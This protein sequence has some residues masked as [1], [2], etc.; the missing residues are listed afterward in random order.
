MI[1]SHSKRV[2]FVHVQKTGGL[3]V[4]GLLLERMDG[5]EKLQGLPGAKHARLGAALRTHPELDD[6][7]V[8][9][10]VRNPWARMWSWYSMI[11]RRRQVANSGNDVMARRLRRNRFWKGVLREMPD[12]EAFVM[13][14]PER[15]PRTRVPQIAYLR[16]RSRTADFIGRTETLTQDLIGIRERLGIDGS[17]QIPHRNAGPSMDYREHYTAA[18]R[19]RVAELFRRD[20]QAFGYE[21]G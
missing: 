8:F 2:L 3:T 10:F 19:A 21:F 16:T 9:G 6:Y 12:F 4:E 17:I 11:E 1:V 13:H 15:F 14:G 5:A 7:W 18:M 20:I